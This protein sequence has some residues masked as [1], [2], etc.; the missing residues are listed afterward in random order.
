VLERWLDPE[1]GFSEARG[2]LAKRPPMDNADE[3]WVDKFLI[4]KKR[5]KKAN[6]LNEARDAFLARGR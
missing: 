6:T 1:S 3:K 4:S 2:E 5:K